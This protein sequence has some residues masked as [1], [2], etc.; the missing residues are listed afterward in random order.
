MRS[1]LGHGDVTSA[2]SVNGSLPLADGGVSAPLRDSV[3]RS[4]LRPSVALVQ[5]G[6]KAKKS[7]PAEIYSPGKST[8]ERPEVAESL[9]ERCGSGWTRPS[10]ATG[11]TPCRAARLRCATIR[12]AGASF[13]LIVQTDPFHRIGQAFLVSAQRREVEILIGGVHHVEAAREAGIGVKNGAGFVAIER[14]DPRRFLDAEFGC[15]EVVDFCARVDLVRL[16]R[17]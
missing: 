1:L 13:I 9:R 4:R 7:R 15:A 10:V 3:L 17:D 12:H 11:F 16:E 8:C 2:Q 5:L 6:L 14:T